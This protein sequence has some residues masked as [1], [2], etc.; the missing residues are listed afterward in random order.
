MEHE[1]NARQAEPGEVSESSFLPGS[2]T[3]EA[4]S[5]EIEKLSVINIIT[6]ITTSI[7]IMVTI[8]RKV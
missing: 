3:L 8:V 4:V 1:Q 5:E 6:I 2:E 7:T